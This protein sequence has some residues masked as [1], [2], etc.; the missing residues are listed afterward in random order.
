MKRLFLILALFNLFLV[1]TFPQ[2]EAESHQKIK[3]A[4]EKRE[5]PI[6]VNELEGIARS[7]RNLFE[8]NNYDYLLARM[9]EKTGDFGKAMAN[10]QS[11]VKRNSILKEY[12]LW[13]LSQIARASGNLM[14]ERVNLQEIAA[15]GAD[16]L[17]VTPAKNRLARSWFESKN[18]DEAI[19]L[20]G[21][22]QVSG[23]AK[24][25]DARAPDNRLFRDNLALLARA[26]FYAGSA[27]KARE[28]FMDLINKQSNPAQPDDFALAAVHGLDLLDGGTEDAKTAPKLPDNDHLQRARI[29]QFNRDFKNARLHYLAIVQN[30]PDSPNVPDAIYQVGRCYALEGEYTEAINWFERVIEQFPDHPIAK[31]ALSQAASAYS[32]VNKPKEAI[33][34]YQKFIEKYPDDERIERPYLNIV[35]ILRDQGS[36]TEALKWTAKTQETFK[37]KPPEAIALFSQARIRIARSEWPD[38]L[39]D[40]DRLLTFPDLGG[41]RVPGGTNTAEVTF[42]KAYALEQ[43]NRFPEAIDTYLSI[44]DGRSEYYGWRATERL[45]ALAGNEKASSF[46]AQKLGAATTAA[47]SKDPETQRKNAQFALR[48]TDLSDVRSRMLETLKKAYALLPAYQKVPAFKLVDIGRR[49]VLQKAKEPAPG[50]L[51]RAIADELI[52]LEL[53]DEAAPELEFAKP[54]QA[55]PTA[56]A[57][58]AAAQNTASRDLDYTLA[59]YFRRGDMANRAVA[60]AE[61]LWRPVPADYQIELI[62]RDQLELLY[63]APY[64]GPL[65]K[66]GRGERDVDPRLILSIMRQESRYRADV[67]SYAAARGLMQF[68]SSTSDRIAGELGRKNFRQDDLYDPSVAILFGSQYV[69][70]IFKLFPGQA[71]AVAAS[72][73]GGEDNM[74]RW[75]TRSQSNLPDRYV[76]EIV[77]SQSK[78]YVYKVMANYRV[79]NTF[80]DENLR[81]R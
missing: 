36:D 41:T 56:P 78:D 57:V 65:L 47:A 39:A 22:S 15:F 42:L 37:G 5:Y 75:L 31:D 64:A 35:D 2:S 67:K 9:T 44:P 58:P 13:R 20:L 27:A 21:K 33:T 1:D 51:H 6:A 7:N 45:K 18:Y 4:I 32:R 49:E 17:L 77:F 60:F 29:Y 63:P 43:M 74:K 25:G 79:Y 68:I 10:Y 34:R 26:N 70:D 55:A 28:G 76:P 23:G 69:A 38:A 50:N 59:V 61:P 52:F 54:S 48:L 71:P 14:L 8:L 30:Y 62:P 46:I 40:L 72:Y 81:P 3:T 66:Y 73:N 19:R 80:Y 16:S 24:P 12:A 53:Y 11:V